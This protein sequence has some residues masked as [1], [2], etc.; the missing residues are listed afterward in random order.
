MISMLKK[1]WD[2]V[3]GSYWF[4][5]AL[6]AV[7]SIALA[8][9]LTQS[10]WVLDL[11]FLSSFSW[12][13]KSTPEAARQVLS[14]IAGSMIT[15]ASVTFSIT[16]AS[17]AYAASQ[18]GPR[19]LTNFMYDRGNQ[20]TLGTFIATFLYSLM[21]LRTLTGSDASPSD[22]FVPHIAVTLAVM[23]GVASIGVLIYFIHHVPSSIH[24]SN[25]ISDVGSQLLQKVNTLYPESDSDSELEA[26]ADLRDAG[27]LDGSIPDGFDAASE[28]R[29]Q[30]DG[31]VQFV[32]NGVLVEL[33]EAL[34]TVVV[35]SVRPGDFVHAEKCLGWIVDSSS[36]GDAEV[37]QF[38][39]AFLIGPK[40][41]AAQDVMFLSRELTE[42]AA[43]ALSP[44]V[45]DP[46][47]AM[48]CMDWLC[49]ALAV[50]A[51]RKTR[52][53]HRGS[54][55]DKVR[56]ITN[57]VSAVY[58]VRHNLDMMRVYAATDR[59]AALY[60][61]VV[62][63]RLLLLRLPA[64][65]RQV[66]FDQSKKLLANAAESLC[67]PEVET[68]ESRYNTLLN[69]SES[70][71]STDKLYLECEWLGGCAPE[72]VSVLLSGRRQNLQ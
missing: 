42:I 70:T 57:P 17:V 71:A 49:S 13:Y 23:L 32:D 15:V 41:T 63:G 40:R 69:M 64:E 45:N 16:I 66:L 20:L 50:M 48:S 29:A 60:F 18:F 25:V 67:A 21:V 22:A 1:C 53:A 54:Q 59:N 30:C 34:N 37:R 61:Q 3:R 36:I 31:F 33:A 6:M 26:I 4:V 65:I 9:Y 52:E 14:T 47:T 62:L 58:F 2:D 27:E 44:G 28:V 7:A 68:L 56:L 10:Q 19:L 12:L 24:A 5:P 35:L 72:G 51:Q 8:L 46:F 11:S 39:S 38:R 43:R 55:G